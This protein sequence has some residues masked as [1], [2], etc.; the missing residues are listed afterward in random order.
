MTEDGRPYAPVRFKEITRE[1][2]EISKRINTSYNEIGDI[3][4]T[5]RAYLLEFALEDIKQ[6]NKIIEDANQKIKS[7]K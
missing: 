2:Y 5:E 4:P 6:Q 1:R 7:K 3:T